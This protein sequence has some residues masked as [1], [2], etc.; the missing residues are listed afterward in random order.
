MDIL[1]GRNPVLEALRAGR[2]AR[3]LV[4][5]AGVGAEGRLDEIV[6]LAAERGI[7][8]EESSRKRLDDIAHTEHH[9]G[10]AGYFHGRLPL[11]LDEL[12]GQSRAPQLVVVLDGIQDPQN[13]GAITRTADAVGA[14]GVVLP[15][16]RA[17][18]VTAA[19]AKASAGATE[20]VP[21]AVVTNLVQALEQLKAAGLWVVGLAADGDTRYDGFD[22]TAPV[23][24][25]I[26]AE[27]E[28]MRALT[29]RHCDV[30]VS[31]PLAGRVSS[32]NAG[33]AAAVLL[34]EVARQ[35]GFAPRER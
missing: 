15:R 16:H 4:I 5:A 29:R 25:V 30:V 26:G 34:Y 21:V 24:V 23:A 7:A 8:V 1:Y 27:G 18:G 10:I 2:P 12:I 33:A 35:R 22:F 19:A 3:K 20:H 17:S 11:R 14:D 31:L 32:L 13:L 9:Q 28:G 6:R